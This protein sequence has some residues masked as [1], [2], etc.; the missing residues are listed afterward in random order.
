MDLLQAVKYVKNS[1]FD[2]IIP[3]FD[4]TS[5]NIRLFLKILKLIPNKNQIF[6]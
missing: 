3:S 6:L 1:P 2:Q 4:D 5:F